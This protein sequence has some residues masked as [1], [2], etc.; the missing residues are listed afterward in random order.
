MASLPRATRQELENLPFVVTDGGKSTQV[1][2]CANRNRT[3]GLA[4]SGRA[5][6]GRLEAKADARSARP[7]RH[8][9]TQ[10]GDSAPEPDT[11]RGLR[12]HRPGDIGCDHEQ[13]SLASPASGIG[14]NCWRRSPTYP[15]W[16]GPSSSPFRRPIGVIRRA[17]AMMPD[18]GHNARRC[19]SDGSPMQQAAVQ[20]RSATPNV[21]RPRL[22]GMKHLSCTCD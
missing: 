4:E 16:N 5:A 19:R 22:P 10:T 8:S 6:F 13:R 2:R 18:S 1:G 12:N 21:L 9:S 17:I 11:P 3:A 20:Q 7:V 15:A 14:A